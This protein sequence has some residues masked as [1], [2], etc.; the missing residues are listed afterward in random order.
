MSF[1]AEISEQDVL[2]GGRVAGLSELRQITMIEA[3]AVLASDLLDQQ[4]SASGLAAE[5]K[6][7][8]KVT[9]DKSNTLRGIVG[10]RLIARAK[11]KNKPKPLV[12]ISA[13]YLAEY[14]LA[15]GFTPSEAECRA[16]LSSNVILNCWPYWREYVQ[17]TVARMNLP[18]I[19]LPFFRVRKQKSKGESSDPKP[20]KG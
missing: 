18:P 13:T 11:Q 1:I 15:Q 7:R 20:P 19:T 3:K 2:R 14:Q 12:D 17:T 6:R 10:F 5:L 9:I 4:V 8:T 16:F